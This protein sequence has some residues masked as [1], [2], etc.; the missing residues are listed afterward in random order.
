VSQGY[1]RL[2]AILRVAPLSSAVMRGRRR[3]SHA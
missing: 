1:V 2:S 3:V